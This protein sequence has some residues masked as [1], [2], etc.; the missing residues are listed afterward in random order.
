MFENVENVRIVST[1]KGVSK[2]AGKVESRKSN[3]FIFRIKGEAVY[4]FDNR[5]VEARE[6]DILFLPKGSSY[7]YETSAENRSIYMS[8]NFEA[9]IKDPIFKVYS[10]DGFYDQ[11]QM[12]NHFTDMWKVGGVHEKYKCYSLFYS[13]LSYIA[14]FEHSEYSDKHKTRIIEPAVKYMKEHMFD[15]DLNVDTLH[16][17]CGISDTYFRRIFVAKYSVSPKRYITDKRLSHAKEVIE[18]GDFA[19]I[20]EVASSIGYNDPLYFSRAFKKKYGWSPSK[21]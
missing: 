17:L 18:N 11:L 13:L 3:A 14:F 16:V 8:V 9:D 5:T 4:Y 15:P 21:I 10:S 7:E 20:S 2:V 12:C 6:G 19:S 1:Y